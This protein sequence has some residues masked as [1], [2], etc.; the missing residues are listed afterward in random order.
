MGPEPPGADPPPTP[1]SR[2]RYV[3]GI[4][5]GGTKTVGLLADE[6]GQVVAETRAG[7]ANLQVHGELEVEKVLDRVLDTLGARHAV[8]AVCLGMA[9]VDRPRDQAVIR[10]VLKRLGHRETARIV[11]DALIALVAGAPERIGIVLLA[12]TGSIAYG[13]D[14]DGRTARAG[15]MG[16]VLSDEGSA[17]W[18]GHASLRAIVRAADGRSPSTLL[19]R[20][21]LDELKLAEVADLVPLLYETGVPRHR[22]AG[23]AVLVERAAVAGDGVA[24]SLLEEA[25]GELALAARSVAARLDFGGKPFPVVLAGGAFRACPSL[26]PR[27][28]ARLALPGAAPLPLE[29]EPAM[30]AVTLALDLVRVGP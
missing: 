17:Y 13:R 21:L 23:L 8:S 20:L 30:G 28:T 15:G 9:G 1:E 4:D 18:L 22:M 3:A 26:V 7:G 24:A 2:C 6:T 27:L 19:T 12:G 16:S 10:G 14:P 5:A 29:V 25:A 11:N